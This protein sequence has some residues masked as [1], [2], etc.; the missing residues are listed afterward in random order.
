MEQNRLKRSQ[1]LDAGDAAL[2]F[3]DHN[4]EA[5]QQFARYSG[6]HV[7]VARQTFKVDLSYDLESIKKLDE[8]IEGMGNRPNNLEQMVLLFGSFLGEAICHMYNAR[9]KWDD[10]FKSWAVSF[11]MAK[12]GQ[13]SAFVFAK[14][15]KRFR[16]GKEDSLSQFAQ[17]IEERVKGKIP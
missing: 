16:N 12:G 2:S 9:W 5:P 4:P 8:L 6:I 14:V 7:D 3:T 15:E 17:A 1:P 11:P 13:E 10:R